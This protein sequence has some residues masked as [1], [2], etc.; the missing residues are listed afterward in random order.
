MSEGMSDG[1]SQGKFS[2]DGG[3][4]IGMEK[5]SFHSNDVFKGG[6]RSHDGK[7]MQNSRS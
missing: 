1:M 3:E 6:N 4:H 2:S 7:G 5:A